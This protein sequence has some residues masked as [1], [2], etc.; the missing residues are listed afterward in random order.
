MHIAEKTAGT[1]K[2]Y[3]KINPVPAKNIKGIVIF[4]VIFSSEYKDSTIGIIIAI[5]II[6][7]DKYENP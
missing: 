7:T 4:L 2:Q 5:I 3:E 6:P 1:N